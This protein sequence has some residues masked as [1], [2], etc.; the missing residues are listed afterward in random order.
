MKTGVANSP[1]VSLANVALTLGGFTLLYTVLGVIDVALMFRAA[2]RGLGTG[3]EE[4]PPDQ[5]GGPT[6]PAAEELVY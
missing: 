6:Q 4:R 2:R 1:S 3:E 5:P